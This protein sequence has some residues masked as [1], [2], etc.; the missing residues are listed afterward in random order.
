[1]I[2]LQNYWQEARRV[3]PQC[4]VQRSDLPP[5]QKHGEHLGVDAPHVGAEGHE[6]DKVEEDEA[7]AAMRLLDF[8][9]PLAAAGIATLSVTVVDG[10]LGADF[11]ALLVAIASAVLQRRGDHRVNQKA[12]LFLIFSISIWLVR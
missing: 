8:V 12:R 11:R 9:L 4:N 1:M 10:G 5:G 2:V 6:A 3:S 7:Q